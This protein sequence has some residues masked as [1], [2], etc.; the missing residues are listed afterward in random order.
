MDK[1]TNEVKKT[2]KKP[3]LIVITKKELSQHIKV[4]ARSGGCGGGGNSR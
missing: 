1:N 4:A 3:I 2:W